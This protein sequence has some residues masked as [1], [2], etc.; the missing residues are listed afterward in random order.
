MGKWLRRGLLALLTV[1]ALAY[2]ADF[3]WIRYKVAKNNDPFGT[4]TVRPY[5]AVPRKDHKLEFMFDD[6]ETETCV[7][8]LFPQLGDRPCWYAKTHKDKRIDL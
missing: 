1:A 3:A 2:G 7:N 5:Y 8:S 6:P 4:L